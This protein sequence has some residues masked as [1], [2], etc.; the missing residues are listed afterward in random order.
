MW[1]MKAVRS[2][3]LGLC[4]RSFQGDLEE[5]MSLVHDAARM[6]AALKQMYSRHSMN[7][8][9]PASLQ[10]EVLHEFQRQARATLKD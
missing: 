2:R 5:A 3:Y 6:K 9:P 1:R 7:A 8:E 4:R 10:Q